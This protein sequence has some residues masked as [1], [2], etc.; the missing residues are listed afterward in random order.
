MEEKKIVKK[1]KSIYDNILF[2]YKRILFKTFGPKCCK[3]DRQDKLAYTTNCKCVNGGVCLDCLRECCVHITDTDSHE[4]KCYTCYNRVLIYKD[5]NKNVHSLNSLFNYNETPLDEADND[6]FL[7][8]PPSRKR[9]RR[10][11]KQVPAPVNEKILVPVQVPAPVI[12]KIDWTN[13]SKNINTIPLLEKNLDKV[14][15]HELSGNMNAIPLLEQNSDKIDWTFLSCNINAIS[16]LEQNLDKIDWRQLSGNINAI[17]LLEKNLDKIDWRQLSRNI[18]AI[19]LLE[20]NLD[21]IDWFQLS[22]NIN[23]VSLLEK[24]LG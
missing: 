16:L 14:D 19:P 17:P 2:R 3:C 4:Y 20:Q 15:W 10:L 23:A 24:K 18:N 1:K 5:V 7:E 13:L 12:D 22:G 21:K 9:G 8:H 11:L 6:V